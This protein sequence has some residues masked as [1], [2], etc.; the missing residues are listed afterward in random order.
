MK[1]SDFDYDLPK[2]QIAQYPLPRRDASRLLILDRGSGQIQHRTFKDLPL[3]FKKGDTLV[4]NDTKVFKGRLLGHREGFSGKIEILLTDRIGKNLYACLGRP[5]RKLKEG[6]KIIFNG[7][8][9]KAEICGEQGDFKL[10]DFKKEDNLHSRLEEIGS[11]PLPPYIK[12]EP[13]REDEIRY[14]T[15]YAS[16]VGAIA[17]PT[18]GLHFTEGLIG[19][20]IAGGVDIISLTLHVGYATFKPVS[21]MDITKHR[22][23]KEYFE[24]SKDTADRINRTKKKTGKVI[25][26]GT[27]T[28]RALESAAFKRNGRYAVRSMSGPTELFIYPGYSFRITD[29]LLTNFHLPRTSLLMLVSAFAGREIILRSYEQ[30]IRKGYRFYSYGDAMLIM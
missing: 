4:L 13:D 21:Q 2:E 27:T 20:L 30:A 19:R 7:G 25:A 29:A 26:V 24:I 3:F 11:V 10:I 28:C 9:L 5:S 8:G 22:M 18:A 6:T 14:Q 17:A 12:R 23:H 15:V 16:K 1:L